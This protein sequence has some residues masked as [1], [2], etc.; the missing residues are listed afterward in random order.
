MSNNVI[1]T[2]DEQPDWWPKQFRYT[3]TYEGVT[4]V[5]GVEPNAWEDF[6]LEWAMDKIHWNRGLTLSLPI[7]FV[8]RG[9]N[10]RGKVVYG[11][12]QIIDAAYAKY[13]VNAVVIFT[14]EQFDYTTGVWAY[15]LLYKKQL[16][17]SKY[18][19]ERDFVELEAQPD[20][21][22]NAISCNGEQEYEIDM[23]GAQVVNYDRIEF[24]QYQNGISVPFSESNRDGDGSIKQF[25]P[26]ITISDKSIIEVRGKSLIEF[27]SIA[28]A[29]LALDQIILSDFW[30]MKFNPIKVG[31]TGVSVDLNVDLSFSCTFPTN[32]RQPTSSDYLQIRIVDSKKNTIASSRSS[33]WSNGFSFALGITETINVA[34]GEKYYIVCDMTFLVSANQIGNGS[35][36]LATWKYRGSPKNINTITPM[37][38]G[39]RLLANV[40]SGYEGSY[41]LESPI[42]SA[43]DN[44]TVTSGDAIRGTSGAKIKTTFNDFYDTFSRLYQMGLDIVQNDDGSETARL[45]PLKYFYQDVEI[46]NLGE[47]TELRI[48]PYL[49]VLPNRIKVGYKDNTYE[50]S[51]GKGEF[52]TELEF[53]TPIR[54][55]KITHELTIPYRADSYGIEYVLVDFEE[56]ETMDGSAD[57]DVFLMDAIDGSVSRYLPIRG[58][59]ANDT[60]FN[61]S[62]SPKTILRNNAELI[63]T[64]LDKI[65][66]IGGYNVLFNSSKK[67]REVSI[68]V[69]NLF[70]GTT[71]F[72]ERNSEEIP[73]RDIL[74][75]KLFRPVVFEF[76]TGLK[77]FN[78]YEVMRTN[79]NGYFSFTFMGKS[80]KGYVLNL[81]VKPAENQ[82][83]DWQVLCHPDVEL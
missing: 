8:G 45:M 75:R 15:K 27:Q 72:Y 51:D 43:S 59:F 47:V 4:T 61:A 65:E 63:A 24:N 82:Q 13:G 28:Y 57:N 78:A 42:L 36:Q 62:L 76:Y 3:L 22:L 25:M 29:A 71:W 68:G 50:N 21:L 52:N 44:L 16:D 6:S 2:N 12:K 56:D 20:G 1:L 46:M 23:E 49:D 79:P 35:F 40:V 30:F 80:Y 77:N 41:N 18:D 9:V 7:K 55:T 67:D 26:S 74:A 58:T 60:M 69:R 5:L 66:P 48:R 70:G 34:A 81:Q 37:Q 33:N 10:S 54:T 39:Q 38:L 53:S 73:G 32:V 19:S 83:Q 14:I 11:G 64:M 17:F 31:N